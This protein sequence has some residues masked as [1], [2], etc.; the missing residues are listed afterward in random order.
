MKHQSLTGI[1]V[2]VFLG[3]AVHPVLQGIGGNLGALALALVLLLFRFHQELFGLDQQVVRG[4]GIP[5]GGIQLADGGIDHLGFRRPV[6]GEQV[7]QILDHLL[8]G[9][10]IHV[11]RITEGAQA[12]ASDHAKRDESIHAF[13]IMTDE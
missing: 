13:F 8:L 1:L 10:V 3:L 2:L 12:E 9:I 4:A 5:A 11:L 6:Q 7:I